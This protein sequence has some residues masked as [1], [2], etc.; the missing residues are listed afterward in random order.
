[1]TP[2]STKQA[3]DNCRRRK[4]KCSR[5]LPCDKC[6]HLLL[7]CSYSDVLRRK[8]PKFRTL[9]PLAPIHAVR[10]HVSKGQDPDAE[11]TSPIS[12]FGA[13]ESQC[14][15]SETFAHLPL[16]DLVS[17]PGTDSTTESANGQGYGQ[18]HR[19]LASQILLAHVNV[20]LKYLFP[21]MPVVRGDQLRS[22]CNDPERL[23]ARRYAFLASL[24]AATHIQLKLDGAAP[25]DSALRIGDGHSLMSGEELLAEAV[26]ARAGCDLLEEVGMESLLTSFFLFASYGNLDRQ[27]HAWFF[28]CQATS[29]AFSL[30]L[31]RESTYANYATEEAEERRR[32]FWLL[33]ITER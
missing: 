22:D 18:I 28:L 9:Y 1:M 27:D 33:F 2:K 12:P 21:I 17:S 15:A 26:R 16:P 14:H 32:V 8:G 23:S 7:S 30:G 4:I 10:S 19:R 24:C 25:V 31:H 5:D 11:L 6:Q 20:Y 3:C 29:F 13:Q